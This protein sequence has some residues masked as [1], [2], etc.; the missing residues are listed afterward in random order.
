[1]TA[2]EGKCRACGAQ[3]IWARMPSGKLN[4]LNVEQVEPAAGKGVVAFNPRTGRAVPVIAA[5]L[6]DC[7][8]WG[9]HGA[10][11]HTS[12]FSDCPNRGQFRRPPA[13]TQ[14][15]TEEVKTT[16]MPERG[17]E[18]V[19]TAGRGRHYAVAFTSDRTTTPVRAVRR[20][21]RRLRIP[22]L[23]RD[24]RDPGTDR[25]VRIAWGCA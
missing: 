13:D 12:H 8:R 11:F 1:M 23:L 21:R 25:S 19:R 20:L 9:E 18:L 3:M 16:V 14:P 4:P 7:A 24:V 5:N 22:A 17:G 10:T 15:A 2:I 6:D